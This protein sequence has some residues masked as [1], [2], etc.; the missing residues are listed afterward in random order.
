MRVGV[1]HR[2]LSALWSAA[3]ALWQPVYLFGLSRLWLYVE[4]GGGGGRGVLRALRKEFFLWP[5][6]M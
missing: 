1:E 6:K 5:P 3:S 4:R 2:R